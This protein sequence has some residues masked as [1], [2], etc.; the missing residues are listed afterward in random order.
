MIKI[1]IT[2][3]KTNSKDLNILKYLFVFSLE[4]VVKAKW[5]PL[6]KT[7]KKAWPNGA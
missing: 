3:K 5:N 6:V 1:S 2:I 7:N 4:K